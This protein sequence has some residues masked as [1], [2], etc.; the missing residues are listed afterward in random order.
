MTNQEIKE[1]ID[2]ACALV[3]PA[4]PLKN[5]VAVNP[6]LGMADITFRQATKKLSET[7]GI[8]MT[9]PI[10]F[11]LDKIKQKQILNIDVA[12]AIA[13]NKEITISAKEFVNYA[14][15]IEKLEIKPKVKTV[16]DSALE[17]TGK[18]WDEFIVDKISSWASSYFDETQAQWNTS[19]NNEDIFTSWKQ[20]AEVDISTEL[21]GIKKF[22][23]ILK[24]VPNNST[25]AISFTLQKLKIEK[26]VSEL[27]LHAL[28][29][30]VIGWSSYIAGKDWNNSLYKG[31]TNNLKSFLSI[32]LSWEYCLLESFS[33]TGIESVWD[34]NK[35]YLKKLGN[36]NKTEKNLLVRIILQDAYDF[37]SQRQLVQK[38]IN[39]RTKKANHKPKIQAVFCIDVRSE[40]Y[41]RNLEQINSEIETIGF[42]GFFGFP[43]NYVPV[44]HNEGKNQCP[45]LIPSGPVVKEIFVNNNEAKETRI[46][47]HQVEKTWKRFKSGAVSSFGFVSP[48]GLSYLPKL[49]SDSFGWTRPVDDPNKDGLDKWYKNRDLDLSDFSLE[50]KVTMAANAITAMGLKENMAELILITGH[51]STSVNNPHATGL[52]CGACGGHTGEINAMTAE[53]ILNDKQVREELLQKGVLIPE[54]THFMACLHDTTTDEIKILGES[55]IPNSHQNLLVSLKASLKKASENTRK[56][57]G[58]RMNIKGD[59][60]D[61]S[62][63][64]RSNDWSQVRPELGLAG[65]NSFIIA[66]RERTVDINLESKSFLHSYNW[67]T[68]KDFKI[69]ESIMTAPMVVTSWINLQYYA[70]TTDNKRMGAGN[71]TLHNVTGGIGVLEGSAGDLRIGLPMQSIHDGKEYQHLP[72]RLSVVIEAPIDAVNNILK[73]HENI[74]NLCD[75]SWLTLL[76]LDNNGEIKQRYTG[77][78]NWE[79]LNTTAVTQITKKKELVTV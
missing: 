56:E 74:K 41:R 51:G 22:R 25:D 50:T 55:N 75:N 72:Q 73:N 37:S 19:Q 17:I 16:S 4:W 6:Y 23:S 9:M 15:Q 36:I 18:N 2:K 38:F 65:C 49:L 68:D 52:D 3:A 58:L 10:N 78:Y 32:L 11:Y 47:K 5:I 57:R 60:V 33:K 29:L 62:I 20:E 46:G 31:D 28:L 63:F 14:N 35:G 44:A 26:E 69:L 43:I 61:A 39:H 42:A 40:V 30:K 71:K 34:S 59:N 79:E 7:S 70:S 45:A 48:A 76:I 64:R 67:Q 21:M 1:V 13:K 54:E 53:K 12:K 8:N 77:D 27:Y 24:Q 66:P